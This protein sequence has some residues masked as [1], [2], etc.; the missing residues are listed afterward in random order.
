MHSFQEYT[1]ILTAI[2]LREG[3]KADSSTSPVLPT[4]PALLLQLNMPR[5][6]LYLL[7]P[8]PQG[9]ELAG[10]HSYFCFICSTKPFLT[11]TTYM[12]EEKHG[13]VE[14]SLSVISHQR[15]G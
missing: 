9:Q 14:T 13:G 11:C 4:A 1:T 6:C 7:F 10:L 3:A 15:R 8:A 5:N 2:A 12:L